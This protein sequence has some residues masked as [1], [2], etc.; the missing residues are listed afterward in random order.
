MVMLLTAIGNR[1]D[2]FA[3]EDYFTLHIKMSLSCV[4]E[5]SSIY[6]TQAQE[7]DQ[8]G[9]IDYFWLEGRCHSVSGL[10]SITISCETHRSQVVFY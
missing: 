6:E 1:I 9:I 7:W 4:V 10:Q 8:A 3:V 2:K 5:M